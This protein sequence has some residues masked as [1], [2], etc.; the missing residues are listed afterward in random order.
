V[1]DSSAKQVNPLALAVLQRTHLNGYYTALEHW[2]RRDLA[3][4]GPTGFG[5]GL[6]KAVVR[7]ASAERLQTPAAKDPRNR[8]RLAVQGETIFLLR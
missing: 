1:L 6:G 4:S 3:E 5:D 8:A 7:Q 2:L